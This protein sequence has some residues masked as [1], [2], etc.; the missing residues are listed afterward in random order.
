MGIFSHGICRAGVGWIGDW[1][2]TEYRVPAIY[3][4]ALLR[5]VVT[6]AIIFNNTSRLREPDVY[7][8]SGHITVDIGNEYKR[9][10]RRLFRRIVERIRG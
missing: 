10:S 8:L 9:K 5:A 7:I 1:N 6:I 4:F 3:R 2:W